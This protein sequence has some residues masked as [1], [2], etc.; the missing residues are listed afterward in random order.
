[1][2][3]PRE[4][5][6]SCSGWQTSALQDALLQ[7][8]SMYRDPARNC[9]FFSFCLRATR[10]IKMYTIATSGGQCLHFST[11]R[12]KK[13]V[14]SSFPRNRKRTSGWSVPKKNFRMEDPLLSGRGLRE[15]AA[16]ANPRGACGLAR[17]VEA[18]QALQESHRDEEEDLER[19]RVIFQQRTWGNV[20]QSYHCL[21]R[22]YEPGMFSTTHSCM[23]FN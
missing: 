10:Y 20:W 12:K 18:R 13:N 8:V 3:A 11:V 1:M 5:A 23:F 19:W 16:D 9:P 14:W 6:V 21:G 4:L 22:R 15:A 2:R 17:A 7:L